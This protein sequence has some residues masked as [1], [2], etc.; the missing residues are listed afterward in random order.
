MSENSEQRARLGALIEDLTTTGRRQLN[1][2]SLKE[3]KKIARTSDDHIRHVFYLLSTQLEKDHA[4]IRLSAVQIIDQL[5]RRSHLFRTILLDKFQMFLEQTVETDRDNPLP[6]PKS[7]AK[8]LKMMTLRL[9]QEWHNEFKSGYKSLTLA[10]NYLENCQ[11]VEWNFVQRQAE[12]AVTSQAD[13]TGRRYRENIQAERA[14]VICVEVDNQKDVLEGNIIE[15]ENCIQLLLPSVDDPFEVVSSQADLNKPGPSNDAPGSRSDR[16]RLRGIPANFNLV[17]EVD[18]T[19]RIMEG[20]ENTDI[21]AN[22]KEF[23]QMLTDKHLPL[24]QKWLKTLS[25]LHGASTYHIKYLIDLKEKMERLKC[26]LNDLKIETPVRTTGQGGDTSDE[27]DD[28]EEVEQKDIETLIP[29]HRREEYGLKPISEKPP[30]QAKRNVIDETTDPTSRAAQ[31][32]KIVERYSQQAKR[33]RIAESNSLLEAPNHY[34]DKAASSSRQESKPVTSKSDAPT[35]ERLSKFMGITTSSVSEGTKGSTAHSFKNDRPRAKEFP[36]ETAMGDQNAKKNNRKD[37][38]LKRAPKVNFD[39]DLIHWEDEKL[40]TAVQVIPFESH[41]GFHKPRDDD[42]ISALQRMAGE[43]RLRERKIDFSGTFEPVRWSCRA[44]L[45]SGRLCPRQDR[46]KCPFHGPIIARDKV[47]KASNDE[48]AADSPSTSSGDMTSRSGLLDWQ[49]PG[50]LRDIE[51]Q[52]GID[53][54]MP[55]KR[56]TGQKKRKKKGGLT[57][58]KKEENTARRRLERKVFNKSS[59]MRVAATLDALDSRKYDDKFGDQWNYT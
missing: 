8:E 20:P 1:E 17:V 33:K 53:L 13:I 6:P 5:F 15:L 30:L 51:A 57:D 10:L 47:G 9:V 52:T 45:P 23:S 34:K 3:L 38:L 11:R 42:Q 43:A 4:E 40:E 29:S 31:Y 37:Q 50:L 26:K 24:V 36:P 21:I 22:L 39:I 18:R 49:D 46:Y 2:A 12:T 32:K 58:V 48:G 7:A 28:F 41:N 14:R 44:P 35:E 19:V 59:V 54:R 25:K 27:D 16:L 55:P 56:G